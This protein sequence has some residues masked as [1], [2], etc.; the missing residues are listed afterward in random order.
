M[1]D[2]IQRFFSTDDFMPHG[3]CYL[4]RPD[5]MALHIVSDALIAIA[6]F[7]IPVF[8]YTFARKKAGTGHIWVLH[9]FAA[10]ILLCGVTHLAGIWVLWNPDYGVQGILKAATALVSV[11]TAILVWKLMPVLMAIPMIS[12]LEESN[13][14]LNIFKRA[15]DSAQLGIM[16]NK[17]RKLGGDI[18]YANPAYAKM[19][20]FPQA[21]IVGSN[22]DTFTD[23]VFYLDG[24]EPLQ[25]GIAA[26]EKASSIITACPKD[27]ATFQNDISMAPVADEDDTNTHWVSF[28]SD[29]TARIA[30]QDAMRENE[31]L[32]RAAFESTP[33]GI[34]LLT[35]EGQWIR[36]NQALC[37]MLGYA[38]DE[39]Q[40][41]DF[42]SITHP[43]DLEKDLKQVMR[44]LRGDIA[45]YQIEKRYICK[46][47]KVFP[48]LLS[49]GLARDARG[50]PLRF[51]S[52]IFDLSEIKS[53]QRAVKQGERLLEALQRNADIAIFIEDMSG[54][55]AQFEKLRQKGVTDLMAHL[56]E[57]PD[58]ATE[59]GEGI[60]LQ[61]LNDAGLKLLGAK[62]LQE[63]KEFGFFKRPSVRPAV[64]GMLK[65]MFEKR[66]TARGDVMFEAIGGREINA[67]Y[68]LP[69]PQS[70]EDAT[71]V[72]LIVVE[73]SELRKAQK[74][75]AASQAKSGFLATMSHEIRSPL[76]AIIG[77]IELIG[78][79]DLDSETGSLVQEATLA[80]KSLLALVGNILDFS[81]IEAGALTLEESAIDVTAPLAEAVDIVMG[82][83]RQKNIS[84]VYTIG[85]DV[86][87]ECISDPVRLRQILL[88][89]VGNAVK[90]TDDGGVWASVSAEQWQGDN[91][92]LRFDVF[93]SGIGFSDEVR[94]ALFQ[95]FSQDKSEANIGREGTGLGLTIA[96]T[97]VERVGGEI[98]CASTPGKGAH[99]WFTWP[100]KSTAPA[101]PLAKAELNGVIVDVVN[102][103]EAKHIVSM[104]ED[105][106][107]SVRT[108]SAAE[109]AADGSLPDLHIAVYGTEQKVKPLPMD[110]LRSTV[111]ISLM[112]NTGRGDTWQALRNGY[113][114][115]GDL[116][117]FAD[118]IDGSIPRLMRYDAE[119]ESGR[120]LEEATQTTDLNKLKGK[121]IL[122]L[123]DRPANQM[124]IRRQLAALGLSSTIAEHGKAGLSVLSSDDTF[125]AILCDCAM[126]V[127]DGFA[128]TEELRRREAAAQS[129]PMPIIA[130]TANAFREDVDR[131]MASGMDDFV[132]K[133]VSLHNLA[134][135][136]ARWTGESEQSQSQR[137]DTPTKTPASSA[138]SFS[139]IAELMGTD[140]KEEVGEIVAQLA[141][142][143]PE[144]FAAVKQAA[145]TGDGEAL[146]TSAHSAKGEANSC[147]AAKLGELYLA[148]ETDAKSGALGNLDQRLAAIDSEVKRVIKAA[149]DYL[150]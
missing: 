4:W 37:D 113:M 25:K 132:S 79:R 70:I 111:A 149:K 141:K 119:H 35:I 108:M 36:V 147:G 145:D 85:P 2:F 105:R 11:T 21:E 123:E 83:A 57:N 33:Q 97:L 30:R 42:Q 93:D 34:A 107:A 65:S 116:D 9:L 150:A 16:I 89:L 135:T 117:H 124:V 49:V 41:I 129:A 38:E 86:P 66:P 94:G 28:N 98:G 140:D 81:K 137:S 15:L 125:D 103:I 56:A 78:Q 146:V 76:N 26:G 96:K 73:V 102:E 131:C 99:F 101:R 68:S 67:V 100:V 77:N 47:G 39:L 59:L 46:D 44:L 14:Q 43:D 90:F 10:F 48:A 112:K 74:A 29:V 27:K 109:A 64:A 121:H 45:S 80:S 63:V 115:T 58:V 87:S 54:I 110:V 104:L 114:F 139:A 3:M 6:Y 7:T 138:I 126:P 8:L 12:E 31:E 17:V 148:L 144:S 13:A 130:L 122:V 23:Q 136:L 134:M 40:Q 88:N 62:D 95:P 82:Q 55:Y 22:I 20:G 106:G 142:S 60:V 50:E 128:F 91:C 143:A 120:E 72:P 19:M 53:A 71:Y 84:L 32:F 5:I 51:V 69:S 52:Q 133:P 127:M 92:V 1:F 118:L 61:D 18:I 75:E 24:L